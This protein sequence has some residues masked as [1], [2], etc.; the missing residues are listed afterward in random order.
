MCHSVA[1]PFALCVLVLPFPTVN[2]STRSECFV[3]VLASGAVGLEDGDDDVSCCI[4]AVGCWSSTVIFVIDPILAPTALELSLS[5]ASASVLRYRT[6][7]ASVGDLDPAQPLRLGV[8]PIL[9]AILIVRRIRRCPDGTLGLVRLNRWLQVLCHAVPRKF[10]SFLQ[11]TVQ[12][13]LLGCHEVQR[14]RFL[15]PVFC[16]ND[17]LV[18]H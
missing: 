5:F 13:L 15:N 17:T 10:S 14:F 16:Q 7:H 1:L 6:R 4:A 11:L 18:N 9:I 8:A 12:E 2:P 3:S